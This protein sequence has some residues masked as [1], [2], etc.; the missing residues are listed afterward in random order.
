MTITAAVAPNSEETTCTG[1]AHTADS[2]AATDRGAAAEA[3]EVTPGP[4]VA[5]TAASRP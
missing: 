5:T 3:A 4:T 1:T 2:A